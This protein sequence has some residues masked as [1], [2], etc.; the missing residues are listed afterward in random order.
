MGSTRS[1]TSR[2][3]SSATTPPPAQRPS[4]GRIAG[5]VQGLPIPNAAIDSI[6][7]CPRVPMARVGI[8]T[9]SSSF[10]ASPATAS[11]AAESNEE[12]GRRQ[13][14]DAVPWSSVSVA[15]TTVSP[16]TPRRRTSVFVQ[17]I[18]GCSV[19]VSEAVCR[20]ISIR[21]Q[22]EIGTSGSGSRAI[23]TTSSLVGPSESV[24]TC[25][26]EP[27]SPVPDG[28]SGGRGATWTASAP[29][30]SGT[31]PVGSVS[32]TEVK[33]AGT[34]GSRNL[35]PSDPPASDASSNCQL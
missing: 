34:S 32:C 17:G 6:T 5:S 35:G 9:I 2:G 31:K 1:T 13:E 21:L 7:T 14:R 11:V 26:A 12:A 15:A 30:T 18:A 33:T 29:F 10:A 8:C 20:S 28:G 23:V 22:H 24:H 4:G 25:S 19:V 3:S 16:A 27:G